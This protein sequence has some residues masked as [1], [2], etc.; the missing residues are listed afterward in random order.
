LE[1]KLTEIRQ[2]REQ[3]QALLELAKAKEVTT[4]TLRSLDDLAGVGDADIARIADG[5]RGR[6][7]KA[8]AQ[9]EIRASRL[10]DQMDQLLEVDEIQMQLEARKRRLGIGRA[11][12]VPQEE[13][14]ESAEIEL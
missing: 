12:D 1:A 8:S 13:D 7:D 11:S 3:L 2:E 5:I 9:A 10:D 14:D 4:K 6:L